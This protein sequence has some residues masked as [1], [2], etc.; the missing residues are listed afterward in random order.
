MSDKHFSRRRGG[1]GGMRFRP[2]GGV[3]QPKR[4]E[5]GAQEERDAATGEK[6]MTEKVYDNSRFRKEIDRAENIA[7][8]LPPEG[9]P[10]P[11]D[12]NAAPETHRRDFREPHMDTPEEVKEEFAPVEIAD[13]KPRNFVEAIKA[14]A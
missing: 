9:A 3:Q 13:P 12:D 6:D 5:R 1:R 8:G 2:S 4:P 7:A 10:R 11:V 14:T